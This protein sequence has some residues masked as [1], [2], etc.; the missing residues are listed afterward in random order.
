MSMLSLARCLSEFN[1]MPAC[2]GQSKKPTKLYN[3]APG[4]PNRVS[5]Q[6]TPSFSYPKVPNH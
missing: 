1:Q 2:L 3:F 6:M 5:K 4:L